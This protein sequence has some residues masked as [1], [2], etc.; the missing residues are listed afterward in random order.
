MRAE[1]SVVFYFDPISPYAWL[2]GLQVARL[3]AAGLQLDFRP[4]LFAGLLTAHGTKGP[5]EIPAKRTYTFR[6]V[7][8]QAAALGVHM[9]GPPGH[10][11][12]PL[13]ALRMCVA[14]DDPGARRRFGLAL[15][16][17]AWRHG[18]DLTAPEQLTRIAAASGLDGAAL[19]RAADDPAIK[20]RLTAQ[21]SAAV[22]AGVFG[23]PTFLYAAEIFWG[24]DRIDA[25]LRRAAGA[26]IDEARLAEALARPA[27][28]TRKV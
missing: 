18:M 16:D 10:P 17:A 14:I 26:T 8:R 19:A 20:Q 23:V 15:M 27:A 11:F 28:A 7:M 2:A 6:D 22:A 5:A 21:T 3:E 13:R 12:N 25:L 9:T 1:T 24:A 4:V